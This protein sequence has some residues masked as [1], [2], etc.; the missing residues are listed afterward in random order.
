MLKMDST[1]AN[2]R[3]IVCLAILESGTIVTGW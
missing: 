2:F 3:P 1:D